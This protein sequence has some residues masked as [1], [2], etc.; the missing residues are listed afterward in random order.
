MSDPIFTL[1][2][3]AGSD[4][5]I[6]P[7]SVSRTGY[8]RA[9]GA[10]AQLDAIKARFHLTP[11]LDPALAAAKTAKLAELG[12]TLKAALLAQFGSAPL[13]GQWQFD[14]LRAGCNACLEKGDLV[15]AAK[16]LQDALDHTLIPNGFAGIVTDCIGLI[17]TAEPKFAAVQAATTIDEVNAIS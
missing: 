9:T 17:Q 6:L 7:G 2:Y 16:G 10:M 15:S 4:W 14:P 3:K 11:P 5:E 1:L 8:Q 13:G 12:A